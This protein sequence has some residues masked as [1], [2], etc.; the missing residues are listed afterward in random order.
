MPSYKKSTK[1]QSTFPPV[2]QKNVSANFFHASGILITIVLTK[3]V[4]K[5]D[6]EKISLKSHKK[7]FFP[8]LT[9]KNSKITSSSLL[10]DTQQAGIISS[11]HGE[12]KAAVS[13]RHSFPLSCRAWDR[14]WFIFKAGWINNT[15]C[16]TLI[17]TRVSSR[18]Q[19]ASSFNFMKINFNGRIRCLT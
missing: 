2:F 10:F 4:F 14:L 19:H 1:L 12:F 6:I 7:F 18:F 8:Q 9:L 15:V 17:S 3:F 11:A 13:P 5:A 16:S